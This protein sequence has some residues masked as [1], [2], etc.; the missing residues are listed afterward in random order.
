MTRAARDGDKAAVAK[1][2][3]FLNS[4][5][6]VVRL[7]AIRTLEVL[8]GQTLG[9]EHAAPEWRRRE[10]VEAWVEWYKRTGGAGEDRVKAGGEEGLREGVGG[11][12][13]GA[14]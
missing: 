6:P 12:V 1:V 2:I 9:Y 10:M 4:D 13:G 14:G 8:T 11:P 7:A 3:P 5:D